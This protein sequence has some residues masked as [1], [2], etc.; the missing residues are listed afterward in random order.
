M[1]GIYFQKIIT[2]LYI[3]FFSTTSWCLATQTKSVNSTTQSNET[4]P[5]DLPSQFAAQSFHDSFHAQQTSATSINNR[6]EE[7]ESKTSI[8]QSTFINYIKDHYNQPNYA[9]ALSQDGSHL[10][11]FLELNNEMNLGAG[12]VYVC[13]RLFYNKIKGCEL[14]DDTVITHL[15]STMPSLLESYFTNEA[16]PSYAY[17]LS[18]IKKQ[19]EQM[20][21][22]QF[23]KHLLTPYPQLN[24]LAAEAAQEISLYY[25]QIADHI[26][27]QQEKMEQRERLRNLIIRFFEI[28]CSKIMWDLKNPATVWQSF[29]NIGV[30]IRELASHGIINHM[31][32]LDDLFWSLTLRFCFFLDFAGA[33]LP[34]ECYEEI[35]KDL[36]N[37]VVFFLEYPEQDSNITSKKET[38]AVNLL[39]AKTHAIAYHKQGIVSMPMV[40]K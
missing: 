5:E 23:T 31:D 25:Q 17:D 11:Q 19:L 30:G 16:L 10:V 38:L 18:V 8:F 24:E 4:L 40:G 15:L 39:Q 27:K 9:L 36:Q 33:I 32:D 28:A 22:T 3:L 37:Q 1:K 6:V 13:L 7:K 2:A 12:T 14:I 29:I 26:Q 20:L 34:L 21:M 35:E